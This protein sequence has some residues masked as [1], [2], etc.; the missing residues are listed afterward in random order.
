MQRIGGHNWSS[1][2]VLSYTQEL[3]QEILNLFYLFYSIKLNPDGALAVLF[4]NFT[5]VPIQKVLFIVIVAKRFILLARKSPSRP[6][7]KVCLHKIV[8]CLYM[9]EVCYCLSDTHYNII[10]GVLSSAEFPGI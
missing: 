10:S 2:L 1:V 9:E 8:A 4:P 6:L 7:F 5:S 3:M